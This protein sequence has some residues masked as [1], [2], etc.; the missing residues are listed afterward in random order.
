LER[1][2][3]GKEGHQRVGK[4]IRKLVEVQMKFVD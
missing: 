4:I 3:V 1:D 2:D